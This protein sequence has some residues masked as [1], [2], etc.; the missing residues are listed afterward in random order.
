MVLLSPLVFCPDT[1][2]RRARLG[3]CLRPQSSRWRAPNQL[4]GPPVIWTVLLRQGPIEW[5]KGYVF[6]NVYPLLAW[7]GVLFTGYGFGW[8]LNLDRARRQPI[9]LA[10]GISMT[11]GF[12]VSRTLH[13]YGEPRPWVP[14][15]DP[16]RNVMAF[17]ACSKYPPSLQFLLMTLG[18]ALTLLAL[19]DRPSGPPLRPLITYGRVPLFYYLLHFPLIH[20]AA[21]GLAYLHFGSIEW[22]QAFPGPNSP[23]PPEGAEPDLAVGLRR[24]DSD[25]ARALLPLPLVGRVE[26]PP[27]G[28]GV[29][30]LLNRHSLRRTRCNASD[31][32]LQF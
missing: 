8:I 3:D 22:L 21:Y 16:M 1:A 20:G 19:V 29:E 31:I 10:L 17:L 2:G 11:L 32:P 7:I 18:P 15:P 24:V 12:I 13:L 26:T 23:K 5:Q 4:P 6:F 28:R 27:S 25:R 9:V 14:Q 30:L